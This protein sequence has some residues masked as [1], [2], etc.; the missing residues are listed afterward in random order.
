MS[1]KTGRCAVTRTFGPSSLSTSSC[2]TFTYCINS[3]A[4]TVRLEWSVHTTS[5]HHNCVSGENCLK[6]S[7]HPSAHCASLEKR[8]SLSPRVKAAPTH[9]PKSDFPGP[10]N[11]PTARM[12]PASD[13]RTS[14]EPS[15]T[16]AR[17][18]HW[19]RGWIK[20]VLLPVMALMAMSDHRG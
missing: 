5:F 4:F 13:T 16:P 11:S 3:S 12:S 2:A 20:L 15:R 6:R 18:I 9:L 10:K 14:S 8:V 7:S 17:I 19:N 1:D